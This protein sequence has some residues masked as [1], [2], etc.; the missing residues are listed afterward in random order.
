M[1]ESAIAF[2]MNQLVGL[3][4]WHCRP[5]GAGREFESWNNGVDVPLPIHRSPAKSIGSGGKLH[6]FF[7]VRSVKVVGAMIGIGVVSMAKIDV[8]AE[9][10]GKV[11][12]WC[13]CSRFLNVGTRS[14]VP[15]V[16]KLAKISVV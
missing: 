7:F 16:H 4:F 10:D 14:A 5:A 2:Q 1:F 8:V 13:L 3:I 15:K 12:P 11:S 6:F 9:V